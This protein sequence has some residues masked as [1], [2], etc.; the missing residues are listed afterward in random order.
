LYSTGQ[1]TGLVLDS[2]DGVTHTVP[3]YE[4]FAF[5]HAIGRLNLAG[6]DITEYLGVLM[7]E[8]GYYNF[9]R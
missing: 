1:Y 5:T 7:N 6:R 3:I 8:R 4:G 9:S 2:G